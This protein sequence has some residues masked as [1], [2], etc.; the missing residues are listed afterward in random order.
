MLIGGVAA[1]LLLPVLVYAFDSA[2]ASGEVPRNVTAAGVDL[3]GLGEDDARAALLEYEQQLSETDAVFVVK[4]SEF[5]LNPGDVGLDIDEDAV[6]AEAM[7]QRRDKGFIGGFFAWFGSFGD[8]IDLAVPVSIQPDRVDDVLETWEAAAIDLPA[9]QGGIIVR[10]TRV[11]PDYPR[12][13]EGSADHR[14]G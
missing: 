14:R 6:L 5:V 2:R 9:Y 3:G 1:L 11:L 10:D 13:G 8:T 12:P 7:D 4:D